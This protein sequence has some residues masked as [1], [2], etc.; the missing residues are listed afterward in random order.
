[1]RVLDLFCGGGGAS[2]GMMRAGASVTGVDINPQPE[3]PGFYNM[4]DFR[5]A[6][7]FS[8]PLSFIRSFD[9]VWASPP[10]Q[11][12]SYAAARWRNSGKEWPDLVDA[13]RELLLNAGV[14]LCIEN[15]AGAPI[16]HD[17]MLCGEMFGLNVIRHRYFE[18]EG[19][20]VIQ[21]DHKKHRGMVKD[22]FYVTVAGNGGDYAGHNFCKLNELPGA[23]QLE[24]WQFAMGI[25]WISNKKT[26]REAVPPAYSEYIISEYARSTITSSPAPLP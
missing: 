18:I 10:C 23:T 1:M 17:L 4:L 15:T 3:H 14:P 26:L 7:V 22:G 9:F 12:Y 21:P 5:H 2:V 16:R 11:A 13:T 19:F 6:D 8:L 20:Q 24:T 25:D